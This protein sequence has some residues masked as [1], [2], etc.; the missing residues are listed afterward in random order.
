M[1]Q[2]YPRVAELY[3]DRDKLPRYSALF[4][5]KPGCRPIL[6]GEAVNTKNYGCDA[7]YV[8]V[9]STAKDP[10]Y[11]RIVIAANWQTMFSDKVG[12]ENLSEFTAGIKALKQYGKEIVFISPHPYSGLFDPLQL[13]K[14]FRLA[15][16]SR[17]AQRIPQNLWQDRL[18]LER[19]DQETTARLAVLARAVGATVI[20]PFDYF[21]TSA[22]CPV[23][24]GGKPLYRDG[25][26]YR[27]S[28]A[29]D[30]ATFID[31]LVEP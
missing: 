12:T 15:L 30:Y 19:Q 27:S 31:A 2:Y 18:Q 9:M 13:A 14:P 6:H 4:A 3:A 8:S 5:A 22:K 7:Y 21:C 29:R 11:G 28:V 26:H 17:D 20:D 1:A 16:F 23:V 10:I 25:W 24:I